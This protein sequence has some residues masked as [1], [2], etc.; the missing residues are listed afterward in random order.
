MKNEEV[1]QKL[2]DNIIEVQ[3]YLDNLFYW[4]QHCT[5]IDSKEYQEGM[6]MVEE[7]LEKLHLFDPSKNQSEHPKII[8]SDSEGNVLGTSESTKDTK[9]DAWY[10]SITLYDAEDNTLGRCDSITGD[11]TSGVYSILYLRGVD[12]HKGKNID[13]LKKV[14][15][16]ISSAG[17]E[18]YL[19]LTS[20]KLPGSDN[21][22]RC[23]TLPIN[24]G[25]EY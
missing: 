4:L 9:K 12:F 18:G 14:E 10:P 21:G 17:S 19:V 6:D 16:T 25:V 23:V 1:A 3:D 8:L 15:V 13:D 7:L 5:E 24:E 20:M 11:A 22:F 2:E